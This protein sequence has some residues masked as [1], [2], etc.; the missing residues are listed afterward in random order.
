[1]SRYVWLL[2]P[3][4]GGIIDGVPQTEG[5]RSPIWDDQSQLIEGKFARDVVKRLS[6]ILD[7]AGYDYNHIVSVQD[8]VSLTE[9]V[10]RANGFPKD[11]AIYISI[12]ANAAGKR[13]VGHG[14]EVFTSVGQ[15]KS[16]LVAE[17]FLQAMGMVFPDVRRR[18]DMSDGDM[19]K[20]SNFYVLRK[21]SMP[22]ILTENF[23]MDTEDECKKYLMTETGRQMIAMA[24]FLAI[25]HVE[26]NGIGG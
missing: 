26:N 17:V 2:D 15:T 21:T 24:H 22:A 4:H 19:D 23:F 6:D 14:V 13:D 5:K 18:T 8:D 9:R 12:H 1:M 10:N 16:D 25:Q 3:G 7:W 11:K 20:E